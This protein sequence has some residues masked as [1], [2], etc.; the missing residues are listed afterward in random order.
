MKHVFLL[1][2]VF[3]QGLLFAQF[4]EHKADYNG[5]VVQ[6]FKIINSPALKE[7]QLS[8]VLRPSQADV[9]FNP[10]LQ[11]PISPNKSEFDDDIQ[12]L[13]ARKD[14]LKKAPYST[15]RKGHGEASPQL[16]EILVGRS[17]YADI[18]GSCPN[19]N[20]IAVSKAG[21][22]MSMMNE[23]VGIYNSQGNKINV[24]TL[25]DFFNGFI[26]ETVCDPKVEYDPVA[27]RFFMFIQGCN[28][29]PQNIA[30]GFSQT[31]DPNGNWAI[32]L[33][34][35]DGLNDGSWSDY[36]K[37]AVNRDEVFIS[38][39]LFGRGASGKYKQSIMYQLNKADG[40]ASKTLR[41]KIWSGFQPGTILP[42]RSGANGQYGPGV[43][44]VQASA[45]GSDYFYFYDITG[46]LSD[47]NSKLLYQKLST[48]AYEP[49]G[50]AYQLGTTIR[51]DIGDC[52]LQDGYYQD[53][54]I[55]FVF[56]ADDQ[57]FSGVRYHR[58]NPVMLDANAFEIFS[59]SDLRDYCYPSIAPFSNN[60]N[61]KSAIIHFTSS[62]ENHY[63]DIRAKLFYNDFSSA[64]SIRVKVGPGPQE[65]CYNSTKN[66]ARWGD[67]T[68]TARQYN[69]SV[70]TV[71][72]AGSVGNNINGKWWTYIAE[73]YSSPTAT[74]EK[75][76]TQEIVL[77]PNPV[78]D[79]LHLEIQ[80]KQQLKVYFILK[81]E[82]GKT[83]SK[84]YEG[85]LMTGE[86]KF[87][88]ST[89]ALS[90]GIYFLSIETE[91][92]EIIKTEKVLVNR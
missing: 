82:Q 5:S 17:F 57:G 16:A 36:P 42:I 34:E 40:Y 58:L 21:R 62:G 1:I 61:D 32:Y 37:I 64:T 85:I 90:N 46:S 88:F 11:H 12:I 9:R 63:P 55:H 23:F 66:Y 89:S 80:V 3:S 51:L 48:V 25:N 27:D 67:Y 65:N 86:N 38:L 59:S 7:K 45:G 6:A 79:R 78:E 77:F 74:I 92:H 19:D 73:L 10:F 18:D 26:S 30:F 4:V 81:D 29:D 91:K 41:Y 50:N 24:Y 53:G 28:E 39:N 44:A 69:A 8:V 31:N 43:Y 54:L 75:K 33:F 14:Y 15:L 22:I 47:P 87:S 2:L 84:M 52:R 60:V 13:K 71:W 20:T 35:S 72:V 56:S 83:I 49:S 68:G 76:L 70:P